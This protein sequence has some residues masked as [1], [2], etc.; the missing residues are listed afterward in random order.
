MIHLRKIACS[1][2]RCTTNMSASTS[3]MGHRLMSTWSVVSS[4][5]DGPQ[6]VHR[7]SMADIVSVPTRSLL[8]KDVKTSGYCSPPGLPSGSGAPLK[9]VC[10]G[11]LVG[12]QEVQQAPELAHAVLEGCPRHQQLVLKVPGL[13]VPA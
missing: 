11:E 7:G 4:P 2:S 6:D 8:L 10:V 13:T 12:L 1:H 9:F 5:I 3:V